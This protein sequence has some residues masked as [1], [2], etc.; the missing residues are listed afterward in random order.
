MSVLPVLVLL[1]QVMYCTVILVKAASAAVASIFAVTV[2]S[3]DR[4][5]RHPVY[6]FFPFPVSFWCRPDTA[7][8]AGDDDDDALEHC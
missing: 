2:A 8:A 1:P 3:I 7:A 6:T 4:R 5:H